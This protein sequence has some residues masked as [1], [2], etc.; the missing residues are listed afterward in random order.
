[1]SA[2]GSGRSPG[3][4][5]LL[6]SL[7]RLRGR[8]TEPTAG[9]TLGKEKLRSEAGVVSSIAAELGPVPLEVMLPPDC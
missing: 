9:W 6:F 2:E 3:E 4:R 1:M 5:A 7:D 8:G